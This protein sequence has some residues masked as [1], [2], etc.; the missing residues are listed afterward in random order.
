MVVVEVV[1]MA[2]QHGHQAHGHHGQHAPDEQ[3]VYTQEFWDERYR[4]ADR[5]WSGNPN[6]HLV[7]TVTGLP[8]GTALDVGCGEGADAV[9]LAEQGWQVTAL[10]VSAVAL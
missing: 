1:T 5:I 6:P 9:W 8:P 2:H 3:I 7:T 4:S 10:D